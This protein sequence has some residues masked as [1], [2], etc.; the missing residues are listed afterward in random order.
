V[1]ATSSH[2]DAIDA[3]NAT[4][5]DALLALY[6]FADGPS[7]KYLTQFIRTRV[8]FVNHIP[9]NILGK[10]AFESEHPT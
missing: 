7:A 5:Q 3:I 10:S 8:S 4:S 1:L 6:V 2:D 9:T